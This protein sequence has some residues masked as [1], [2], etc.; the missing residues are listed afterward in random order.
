MNQPRL[1]DIPRGQYRN[2]AMHAGGQVDHRHWDCFAPWDAESTATAYCLDAPGVIPAGAMR[3][4]ADAFGPN[5]EP[6]INEVRAFR[7]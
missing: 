7:G 6:I 1:S 5:G 4:I 2:R 3:H